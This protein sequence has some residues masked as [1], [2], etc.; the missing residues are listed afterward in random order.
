VLFVLRTALLPKTKG[1]LSKTK[2]FTFEL[3]SK[4]IA[5]IVRHASCQ[6]VH[7]S[8][9]SLEGNIMICRVRWPTQLVATVNWLLFS[10]TEQSSHY[11]TLARV[12]DPPEPRLVKWYCCI[13]QRILRAS[14]WI[15]TITRID[16]KSSSTYF[17]APQRGSLGTTI[18]ILAL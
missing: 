5:F 9:S 2:R 15:D 3:L 10:K 16:Y 11:H 18:I 14:K 8:L 17:N 6:H 7:S 12:N 1:V 4:Q 13:I